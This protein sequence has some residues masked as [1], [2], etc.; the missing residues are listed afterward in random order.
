MPPWVEAGPLLPAPCL[1]KRRA[2]AERAP[3]SRPGWT[4]ECRSVHWM[5]RVVGAEL[6]LPLQPSSPPLPSRGLPPVCICH[7]QPPS[8][9]WAAW[10]S[11]CPASGAPASKLQEPHTF[12]SNPLP[13]PFFSFHPL[14]T[15][16]FSKM[17]GKK[18]CEM[19]NVD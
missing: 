18:N 16:T 7:L 1:A 5:L 4:W 8:P 19:G 13:A 10:F 6:G 2:E 12:I 17:E 9:P 3:V 11:A 14:P 15:I